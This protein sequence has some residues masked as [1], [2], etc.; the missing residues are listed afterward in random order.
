MSFL[1]QSP[2][3]GTEHN[4]TAL[5]NTQTYAA[6]LEDT[7]RTHHYD[8]SHRRPIGA[9]SQDTDDEGWDT[10]PRPRPIPRLWCCPNDYRS[11]PLGATGSRRVPGHPGR[12]AAQRHSKTPRSGEW[13]SFG[14]TATWSATATD[15]RVP[16]RPGRVC[17]VVLRALSAVAGVP[18]IASALPPSGGDHV[19]SFHF[20]LRS[21]CGS[22]G[23]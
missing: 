7:E 23:I 15:R 1:R 3:N 8:E 2:D 18:L 19:R 14:R 12:S 4:E 21:G 13:L 5:R 9:Q 11:P 20:S 10:R 16:A 6:A 17:E 22:D